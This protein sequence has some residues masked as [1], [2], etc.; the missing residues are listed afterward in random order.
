MPR[1]ILIVFGT[2]PEVIKLAPLILELKKYPRQFKLHICNTEQQK[3]LSNQILEFFGITADI[4]LN[5]MKQNQQLAELQSKLLTSLQGVFESRHIDATIVQGDTM[6]ACTGALVSFYRKVPIFHLEAG[7]RSYN[8]FEPFPEEV[9]RV[10]ISRIATLHFTPTKQAKNALQKE[11]I[12]HNVFITGNTSIDSLMLFSAKINESKIQKYINDSLLTQSSTKSS[13]KPNE[14]SA[15][16]TTI[17]SKD[18]L[19]LV[20]I[21]RRE[22]HGE[23]L[24]K[25]LSALVKLAKAFPTHQFLIPVHPNPN[26]KQ[27][28]ITTLSPY[29]NVLLTTPLDYPAIIFALKYAKLIITDSGGIQEEAPS[30]GAPILVARYKTERAEAIKAGFSV[31][32]GAN[33]DKIVSQAKKILQKDK[34]HTRIKAKNPYGDGKASQKITKIIKEFFNEQ[35]Q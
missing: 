26:V 13:T 29:K 32:V 16:Q 31:L 12:K 27:T 24:T 30:F 18:L 7:L 4:S 28:I 5:V 9:M 14:T 3:D 2:R 19:V 6:S 23:R 17:I 20:T 35:K 22:N 1:D 21:H 33:E 15:R 10:M 11:N 8:N 25:I 34:K